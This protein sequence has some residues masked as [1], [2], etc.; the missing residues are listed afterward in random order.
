[1]DVMKAFPESSAP[2]IDYHAVVLRGPSALSVGERELIAAYVSGL[3]ACHYCE[4]VHG[5]VTEAFGVEEGVLAALLADVGTAPVRDEL[6]P[7]FTYVRKLTL[8]P[9]RMAAAD[10]GAVF[11]AGWEE[12]TLFDA[13]SVCALCAARGWRRRRSGAAGSAPPPAARWRGGPAPAR[14]PG[15]R[16][17]RRPVAGGHAAAPGVPHHVAAETEFADA[18]F[19]DGWSAGPPRPRARPSTSSASH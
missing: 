18:G 15:R 6:K 3:N 9:S 8:T 16:A 1:M 2:L 17:A 12:K 14:S 4:G 19:A 5:A 7:L 13:V 10:A 11:A